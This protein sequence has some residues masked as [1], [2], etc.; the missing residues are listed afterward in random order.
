M[1][2]YLEFKMSSLF[3]PFKISQKVI[4]NAYES[5]SLHDRTTFWRQITFQIVELRFINK[6]VILIF[7]DPPLAAH[8]KTQNLKS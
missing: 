8:F 2:C 4:V 6:D 1:F 7:K 5:H 3:S